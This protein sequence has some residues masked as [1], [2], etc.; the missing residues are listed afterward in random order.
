MNLNNFSRAVVLAS[1]AVATNLVISSATAALGATYKTLSNQVVVTGLQPRTQY[2]VQ[3]TNFSD[4]NTNRTITT[5]G[6]GEALISNGTGYRRLIIN[7]QIITPST[8]STQT[9]Q[10]CN[11][12]RNSKVIHT[13]QQMNR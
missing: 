8:L 5:N 6:C 4:R 7:Q 13:Q 3:T 1:T 12:R 10:R 2:R 11:A 9:H